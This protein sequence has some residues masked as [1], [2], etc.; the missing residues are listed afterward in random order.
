MEKPTY[1][2]VTN[3]I[4]GV[5]PRATNTATPNGVDC[6]TM[7]VFHLSFCQMQQLIYRNIALMQHYFLHGSMYIIVTVGMVRQPADH[8]GEQSFKMTEGDLWLIGNTIH[9]I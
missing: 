4:P 5:S 6:R 7:I 3:V 2:G 1:A 8:S 9:K